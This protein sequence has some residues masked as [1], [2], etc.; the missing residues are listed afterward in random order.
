MTYDLLIRGG[1]V[2]DPVNGQQVVSDVAVSSGRIAAV[3][4]DL[5]ATE[6]AQV[7][8]ASGQYITPGLIDMHTHCYWGATYWGIEA[9][10][11]TAH[12][13]V[14]TWVDAGSSGAYSFPGFRR[15]AVE[16][17]R[18][19]VFALLHI[20]SIGLIARTYESANPDYWDVELAATIIE[21][22]RDVILGIKVRMDRDSTKGTGLGA[23][24]CARQLAD[25]VKLPLMVHIGIAPPTLTEIVD[26][27]RPGDILT[28]CCTGQTNRLIDEQGPVHPYI[29][30][31]HEQGVILDLGHG[32]GS[33]SYATAEA[34]LAQGIP[35]DV[36]SSDIHQL[37]VL[38]PM[39]DLPTTLSKFLNLGMSLPEVI[40]RATVR[41]AAVIGRPGLGTL[42]VGVP[43]D[44]ALFRLEEGDYTFYDIDL[45]PRHGTVRLVNTATYIG[46]SLVPHAAERPP[47]PWVAT[48]FPAEQ[49]PLLKGVL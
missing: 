11:V 37:A 34:M 24:H 40:A 15:Y 36:L 48:D 8:D 7:V 44:I 32:T 47:H 28:H 41:P 49:R 23:M 9:D 14:T 45:E 5:P 30:R 27:M 26:L 43:A 1:V 22:N 38:G 4:P 25:R 31:A 12:T 29:R 13:G 10:P 42:R 21:A 46:G 20:S 6:A 18:T 16:A 35:P 17:S 39:Y 19:R 33:F 2:I 3:A